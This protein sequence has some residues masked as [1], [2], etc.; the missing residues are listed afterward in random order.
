MAFSVLFTKVVL[1]QRKVLEKNIRIEHDRE[2]FARFEKYN[3]ILKI[4][5][6]GGFKCKIMPICPTN[7]KN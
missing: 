1:I 3:I 7:P 6:L 4:L 2:V 5:E